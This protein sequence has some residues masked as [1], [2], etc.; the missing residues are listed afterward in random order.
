MVGISEQPTK[1]IQQF[2]LAD[3]NACLKLGAGYLTVDASGRLR[4]SGGIPADV[5]E[6]TIV[7]TQS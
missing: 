6:G 2:K 4:I 7:G 1:G 5:D 3:G